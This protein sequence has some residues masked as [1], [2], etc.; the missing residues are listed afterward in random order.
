MTQL[1]LLATDLTDR[2]DGHVHSSFR[3]ALYARGMAHD[4]GHL[5]AT[6]MEIVAVEVSIDNI[7]R[8]FAR[9]LVHS[10]P[11]D[12]QALFHQFAADMCDG[13]TNDAAVVRAALGAIEVFMLEMGR[14]LTH[15][16]FGFTL[17]DFPA[18]LDVD[19][20]GGRHVRRRMGPTAESI[21]IATL[22]RDRLVPMLTVEQRSGYDAVMASI[23]SDR[24]CKVMAVLSSAGCG[25]TVFANAIASTVRS[26]GNVA[27]C[28]AASALAAMLLLGGTTAHSRFHIPIPADDG[29]ICCWSSD[30]RALLRSADVILYDECSMVHEHVADTLERSL[31]DLTHDSRPFGGKVIIFMGDFKQ[32]L[33]VVRYGR[34]HEH[35]MQRCTW[36]R[37]VTFLK[38]SVNWR[39][40]RNPDFA[41]MLESIGSGDIAEVI[42]PASSRVDDVDALILEVYGDHSKLMQHQILA[43][44][45]ETCKTVNEACLGRWPG[46]LQEKFATDTYVDCRDPDG[47]PHE[48]I[49]SLQM[50]GAP[51]FVLGLK[52]GA[53]YMCVR[54]IDV[55]R[56]LANGT[57]LQLLS[58]SPRFLQFRITSGSH[59][60]AVEMLI[61]IVFHITSESSGLPFAIERRQYPVIPAFCLSVHKAQGQSLVFI[62]LIFETDPFAHGQLYV[63]LSR[64]GGWDSIRVVMSSGVCSINNLVFQ[65]LLVSGL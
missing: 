47:F 35:T 30:D 52:I 60:G 8:L 7:R 41:A 29:S 42:V 59:T 58:V 18:D 16:D 62:G 22:E 39:A 61:P 45:L 54:N 36:W 11:Q 23:G 44:T 51:P 19:G 6:M 65:H 20:A 43:L 57:M 10:A 24:S 27:I 21:R 3:S 28:V 25:K 13:D 5:V 26:R 37:S 63:A 38:F 50:P 14:S 64:A 9:M 15:E 56:G 17:D 33:P 34:G 12:A 53:K 49:E 32:L 48:Y 2:Q 55:S 40:I 31:R 1:A 4:D 46:L